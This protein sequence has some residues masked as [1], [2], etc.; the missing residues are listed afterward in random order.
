MGGVYEDTDLH[1]RGVIRA[2]MKETIQTGG[3]ERYDDLHL[4]RIEADWRS[5]RLWITAGLSALGMALQVRNEEKIDATVALAFSLNSK[6]W[7]EGVDFTGPAELEQQF[8][9]SPPSLYLFHRGSEPWGE[10]MLDLQVTR[11]TIVREI[12]PSVL[13]NAAA[14]RR[15]V[16][17]EFFADGEYSRS[18]FVL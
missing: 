13:G 16:Y 17:M 7:A 8:N 18:L 1:H 15:C 2:W 10:R 4:D 9:A 6:Q 5:R 3:I 12:N 14:G 11:S